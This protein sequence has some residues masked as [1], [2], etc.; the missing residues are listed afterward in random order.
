M[1]YGLFLLF[2]PLFF[3][4]VIAKMISIAASARSILSAGCSIDCFNFFDCFTTP[5]LFL[6]FFI[7]SLI[8]WVARCTFQLLLI[9]VS[10]LSYLYLFGYNS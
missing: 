2:L 5:G 9:A 10:K 6:D 7:A 4:F 1:Y 8:R 3:A